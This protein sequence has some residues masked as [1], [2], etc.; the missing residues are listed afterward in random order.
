MSSF[1]SS[2]SGKSPLTSPK[3]S[4]SSTRSSLL[5]RSLELPGNRVPRVEVTSFD[6]EVVTSPEVFV[7]SPRESLEKQEPL[8]EQN[9]NEN[10]SVE[11]AEGIKQSYIIYIYIYIY[12]YKLIIITS[13]R[14]CF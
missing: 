8:Q 9:V 12:I 11:K 7:T 5:G 10:I 3:S 13:F 1:N 2:V 4:V 14:T 6:D